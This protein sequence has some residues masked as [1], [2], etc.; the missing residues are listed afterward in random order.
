M[1]G[2]VIVAGARPPSESCGAD[3]RDSPRRKSA[4]RRSRRPGKSGIAGSEVDYM[5]MGQVLAAG[6]ITARQ[7]AVRACIPMSILS[8]T[9]SKVCLSGTQA[10]IR[11]DQLICIGAFRV[12][13][14]GP[15][16]LDLTRRQLRRLISGFRLSSR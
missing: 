11:A 2:S 7:A 4:G 15:W 6:P 12:I 1:S 9:L 5:I 3:C 8:I 16:R 14:A 13:V 10:V